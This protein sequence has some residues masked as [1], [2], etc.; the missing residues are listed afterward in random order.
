M[1]SDSSQPDIVPL[2]IAASDQNQ[3]ETALAWLT[4]VAGAFSKDLRR[5]LPFLSRQR[6]R[7]AIDVAREADDPELR[8]AADGPCFLVRLSSAEHVWLT[9]Q[10]DSLAIAALLDGLFAAPKSDSEDQ[11]G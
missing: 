7:T 6:A 11:E 9:L 3:S 4:T 10:F 8:T 1:L 5:V 2:H